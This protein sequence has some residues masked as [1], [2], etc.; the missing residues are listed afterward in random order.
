MALL[1]NITIS[2]C[3][4]S[5]VYS[6]M[7]LLTPDRFKRQVKSVLSI[8]TAVTIGGVILRGGFDDGFLSSLQIPSVGGGE[9]V[10]EQT[11]AELEMRLN[12]QIKK[13]IEEKGVPTE[14]VEVNI[15]IDKDNCI[16]ISRLFVEVGGT[17][18]EYEERVRNIVNT[19]IGDVR[20]EAAFTEVSDGP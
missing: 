19:Q 14:K 8:V 6:I 2:I 3:S 10:S 4:L 17:R 16:F 11:I 18:S 15:D 7:M 20:L 12:E 5:L 1:K 13:L 9:T